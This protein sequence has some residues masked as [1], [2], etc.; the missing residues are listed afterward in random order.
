LSLLNRIRAAIFFGNTNADIPQMVFLDAGISA[1]FDPV[2]RS[3]IWNF[4]DAI[5]RFDGNLFGNITLGLA[6]EQPYVL[7]KE[8]YVAQVAKMMGAMKE[9]TMKKEKGQRAGANI[10]QMLTII[11]NNRVVIDPSVMCV[12]TSVLILEG[13]QWRLDPKVQVHN[14]IQSVMTSEWKNTANV[15]SSTMVGAAHILVGKLAFWRTEESTYD[16]TDPNA[17][18]EKRWRQRLIDEHGDENFKKNVNVV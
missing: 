7:D 16:P 8:I 2:Y 6:P 5:L 13:W 14:G 11:R 17:M 18:R 10:R 4:F 15:L 12:V 9:K 1:H 3:F